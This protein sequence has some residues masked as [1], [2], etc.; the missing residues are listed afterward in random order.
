MIPHI[1]GMWVTK[2]NSSHDIFTL[3][4]DALPH[5]DIFTLSQDALPHKNIF[6][7]SQDALPSLSP[8]H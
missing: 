5:K 3:S 8:F 2:S 4:Q 7:L 6:T 1:G